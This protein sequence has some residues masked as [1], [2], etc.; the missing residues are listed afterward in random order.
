MDRR[1]RC[2]KGFLFTVVLVGGVG[3]CVIF[4]ANHGMSELQVHQ[5]CSARQLRDLAR[6]VAMSDSDRADISHSSLTEFAHNIDRWKGRY[7][8]SKCYITDKLINVITN[9]TTELYSSYVTNPAPCIVSTYTSKGRHFLVINRPAFKTMN[10]V[11]AST[12]ESSIVAHEKLGLWPD[13]TIAVYLNQI[14]VVRMK[15]TDFMAVT[16]G[17]EYVLEYNRKVHYFEKSALPKGWVAN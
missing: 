11:N 1:L 14:G 4:P 7:Q 17:A 6:V 3:S 16:S 2:S 5:R 8:I 12:F 13:D 10:M 9:M 15:T